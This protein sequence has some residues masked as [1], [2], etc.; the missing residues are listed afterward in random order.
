MSAVPSTPQDVVTCRIGAGLK[1]GDAACLS[2]NSASHRSRPRW[3]LPTYS[4][5]FLERPFALLRPGPA[6]ARKSALGEMAAV[7]Q[8]R[9]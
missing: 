6:G 8:I 1:G 7:G 3:F 4:Y 9:L 2:N 5:Q